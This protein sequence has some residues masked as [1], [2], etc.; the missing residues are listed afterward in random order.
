MRLLSLS[1]PAAGGGVRLPEIGTILGLWAVANVVLGLIYVAAEP[2]AGGVPATAAGA[3]PA[4][5]AAPNWAALVWSYLD[6]DIFQIVTV[7]L[8]FP[9]VLKLIDDQFR[10]RDTIEKRAEE[11]AA[12]AQAAETARLDAERARRQEAAARLLGIWADINRLAGEVRFFPID[13]ERERRMPDIIRDLSLFPHSAEQA[14]L[15][16]RFAFQGRWAEPEAETLFWRTIDEAFVTL[17]N[18]IF[19]PTVF[20]AY[21]VMDAGRNPGDRA[22]AD[23][24]RSQELLGV[25]ADGVKTILNQSVK[26]LLNSAIKLLDE[27]DL[28][29]HA[30]RFFAGDRAR[31]V[32]WFL[33]ALRSDAQ[34]LGDAAREFVAADMR[35]RPMLRGV[36]AASA[37]ALEPA[38]TTLARYV[39][40]QRQIAGRF[41]AARDEATLA[42]FAAAFRALPDAERIWS[43]EHWFTDRGLDAYAET[44]T[45]ESLLN[46]VVN[47]MCHRLPA[48]PA[49]AAAATPR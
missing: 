41:E 44:A 16:L 22:R 25:V 46:D 29:A 27:D 15:E 28:D 36:S 38:A 19:E 31:S 5:A 30:A 47:L 24:R 37:Q 23:L 32:A 2:G 4:A 49:D 7:A 3:S 8:A 6:S 20:V 43:R 14:L 48:D 12:A 1:G 17:L 33:D 35:S 34:V 21:K 9:V 10:I 13:S 18:A 45:F 39:Q 11:R 26:T 40:E 42:S